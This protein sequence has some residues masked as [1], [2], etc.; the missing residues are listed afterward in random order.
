MDSSQEMCYGFRGRLIQ[1]G[2]EKI[3]ERE[4][5]DREKEGGRERVREREGDR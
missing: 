2:R 1:G 5:G 3:R 4:G